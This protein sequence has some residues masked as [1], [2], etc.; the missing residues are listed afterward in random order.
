MKGAE[1]ADK[2]DKKE[3]PLIYPITNSLLLG[4]AL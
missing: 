1:K 3:K 2:S 4:T